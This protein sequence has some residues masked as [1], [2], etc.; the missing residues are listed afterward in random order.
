M[1]YCVKITQFEG[2][3]DLLLHL[4]EEAELDIKDIFVSEITAQYLSIMQDVDELDM[5][6][7][8]E[9]L[10][11]AATLLYIK[12]RQLLPRPPKEDPE[13]EDPEILLIRQLREYK[14]FKEASV[15]LQALYDSAKQGYTRLPED[16]ILPPKQIEIDCVSLD[17]LYEA[18]I[19]IL[20][21]VEA[22]KPDEAK[23]SLHNIRPD[24]YTVRHQIKKIRD[25]LNAQ[26]SVEF[27]EL[28]SEDASRMEMI[29]TFMALLEMIGHGE[30][31]FKQKALFAPI[32]ISLN[33]LKREANDDYY[34]MDEV[35]E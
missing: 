34:Y 4:I 19:T 35:D 15:G 20:N 33:S 5:D 17:V 2:P 14:A 28:F 26:K 7:A 13:D 18:W 10:V 22:N 32:S 3:L 6:T 23:R 9:F 27:T 1:A 29:V 21:R 24:S 8:S 30:I 16:V 31:L 25:R 12:S 11:M